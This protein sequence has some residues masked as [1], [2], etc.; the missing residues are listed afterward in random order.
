LYT[1]GEKLNWLCQSFYKKF[2]HAEERD[3]HEWM[4]AWG[5]A[6]RKCTNDVVAIAK[7]VLAV[8]DIVKGKIRR[9]I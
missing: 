1:H 7:T 9:E 8:E 6:L 3:D 5:E 2:K 4:L